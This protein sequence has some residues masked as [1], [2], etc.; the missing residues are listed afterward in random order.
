MQLRDERLFRQRCYVNGAWVAA[1][2]GSTIDVEDPANG[3]RLGSVPNAGGEETREAIAAA[4]AAF[5]LWRAHTGKERALILRRWY[6]LI[7]Q[8]CDDLPM[9]MTREH[10]KPLAESRADVAYR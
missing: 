7:M 6:D 5:P 3:E 4:A 9:L 10:G 8:H 2:S 1:A